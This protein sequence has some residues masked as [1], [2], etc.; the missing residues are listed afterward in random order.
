MEK[1]LNHIWGSAITAVVFLISIVFCYQILF[2]YEDLV[3]SILSAFILTLV[4]RY[5]IAILLN[6]VE[7]DF[8]SIREIIVSIIG[9]LITYFIY[10]N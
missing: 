3:L 5:I 2:N 7:V 6:N 1:F 9:C 10:K 4:I 8:N